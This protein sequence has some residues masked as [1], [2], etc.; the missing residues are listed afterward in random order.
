MSISINMSDQGKLLTNDVD[1][2]TSQLNYKEKKKII[3]FDCVKVLFAW[4]AHE[5]QLLMQ[6]IND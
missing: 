1:L 4:A 6:P 3:Q 5:S 2:D